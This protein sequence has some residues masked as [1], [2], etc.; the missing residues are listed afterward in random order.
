[1]QDHEHEIYY[2]EVCRTMNI[3][4]TTHKYA[5]T[6]INTLCISTQHCEI[7][8]CGTMAY[9]KHKYVAP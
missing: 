2:A 7:C 3:K 6:E 8:V 9:T 4:Y 5:E 1:M